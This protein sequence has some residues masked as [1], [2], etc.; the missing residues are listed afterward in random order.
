MSAT[1]HDGSTCPN[2][3]GLLDVTN[4]DQAKGVTMIRSTRCETCGYREDTYL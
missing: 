3:G 2:C 1:N 4:E